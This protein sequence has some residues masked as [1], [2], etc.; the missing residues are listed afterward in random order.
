MKTLRLEDPIFAFSQCRDLVAAV[1]GVGGMRV[2]GTRHITTE[3]LEIEHDWPDAH[4]ENNSCSVDLML[5]S[6]AFDE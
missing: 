3:Q 5:A 4:M 2:L 1:S 6:I